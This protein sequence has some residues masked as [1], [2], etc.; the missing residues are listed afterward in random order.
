MLQT[1]DHTE[2]FTQFHGCL[3][4]TFG[5]HNKLD[6]ISSQATAIEAMASMISE[7]LQ[8]PK[9]SKNSQQRQNQIDQQA[10]KIN[11][12]EAQNQ[13]LTQLMEP[14]VLVNTITQA[15]A[16]SLNISGGNKPQK[17]NTNGTSS[18]TGR[19]PQLAP[20]VDGSLDPEL[21]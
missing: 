6:R 13:K 2:S 17:S 20:G 15:V 18:Y 3:A 12:L 5:S 16:S 1:S 4:L 11:G 21:S 14:K 7:V 19:P 10:S 8:E 9:L